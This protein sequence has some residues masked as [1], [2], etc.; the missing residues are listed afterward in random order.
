M[1]HT[2]IIDPLDDCE[3]EVLVVDPPIRAR[4]FLRP[5]GYVEV[6][7]FWAPGLWRRDVEALVRLAMADFIAE[8]AFG[9]TDVAEFVPATASS[10]LARS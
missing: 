4:A 1:E 8:R 5:D 9:W 3:H 7:Q 10:I 6:G 2:V